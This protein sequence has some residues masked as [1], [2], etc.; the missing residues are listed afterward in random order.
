MHPSRYFHEA[1]RQKLA[2]FVASNALATIVGVDGAT[3]ATAVT[4]ILATGSSVRF[5]LSTSNRLT[6]VLTAS[7]SALATIVA[8]N[9]Y[10]SPD[11]YAAADQVP[12]WNYRSVEIEGALRVLTRDETRQLLDD[13]SAHFE[14]KLAPKAP[15]T[16]AKMRSEPFEAMLSAIIGFEMTIERMEGTF[17]LSQN[18]PDDERARVAARLAERP[19]AGSQAV[20]ALMSARNVKDSALTNVSM[21]PPADPAIAPKR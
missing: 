12:T 13:L 8:E 5:H 9:A 21:T 10:I 4:P 2:A 18:K 14:A 16:R 17:K 1:D 7:R 15:W 20:A 6:A 11:W 3:A 19:D